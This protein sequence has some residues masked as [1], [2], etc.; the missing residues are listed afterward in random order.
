MIELKDDVWIVNVAEGKTTGCYR[1]I[2]VEVRK[3]GG[4]FEI[5]IDSNF[6]HTIETRSPVKAISAAKAAIDDSWDQ[7]ELV[8]YQG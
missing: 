7:M 1:N 5:Y 4:K 6:H 2:P 3:N 8:E